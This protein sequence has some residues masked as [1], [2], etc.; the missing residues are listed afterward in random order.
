M[1]K[2]RTLWPIL[3]G[4]GTFGALVKALLLTAQ[5][6]DEVANMSRSEIGRDGIWTIPAERYKT[7]KPNFVPLSQAALTVIDAQPE[8]AECDYVFPS[9]AGTPFSAFGK[10]KAAL[11]KTALEAMRRHG[12]QRARR[13]PPC[14]IGRFTICGAPQRR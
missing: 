4:A 6:R 2:N 10:N 7:K 9:G 3:D 14:P 8:A 13:S 5:R 12:P 1:T 11:D